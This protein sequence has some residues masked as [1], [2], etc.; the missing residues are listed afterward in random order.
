MIA[1]NRERVESF[2]RLLDS[3]QQRKSCAYVA[4]PLDS[5][6]KYYERLAFEKETP[7]VRFENEKRLSEFALILRKRVAFPVFDPGPLR[8]AGWSGYDYSLFF[9]EIVH[10][11]V[12]EC[13]FLNGW[14]Y[15]VGATK[16]FVF[17]CDSQTPC[18]SESGERLTLPKGL[19]LIREAAD[20]I[21]GLG[22]DDNKFRGRIADLMNIDSGRAAS[23]K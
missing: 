2:F 6:R 22:L 4:C 12:R 17:C 7:N 13:W 3:V 10:R 23:T 21:R 14:Q 19:R 20:F 1:N 18:L 9:L 5:G 15:S 8:V 16:E 11:Y